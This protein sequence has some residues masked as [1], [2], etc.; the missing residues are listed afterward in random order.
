[1][2]LLRA[3]LGALGGSAGDNGAAMSGTTAAER[4]ISGGISPPERASL[5]DSIMHQLL[6]KEV[7]NQ[8]MREFKE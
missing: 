2:R 4:A 5:V 3:H 7:L 6:S 1:M 8:P